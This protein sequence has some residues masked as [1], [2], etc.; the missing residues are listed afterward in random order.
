MEKYNIS[1]LAYAVKKGL[2]D[3]GV[4]HYGLK[5]ISEGYRIVKNWMQDNEYKITHL[6]IKRIS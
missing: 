3:I 1:F 2:S 4:Q 5:S 6:T